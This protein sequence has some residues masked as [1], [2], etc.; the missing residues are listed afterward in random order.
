MNTP[1]SP[2]SFF[3]STTPARPD[4]ML[5]SGGGS[6]QEPNPEPIDNDSHSRIGFGSRTSVRRTQ[7]RD[8]AHS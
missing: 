3:L 1:C 2:A 6:G 8:R 5:P 4:G 7:G